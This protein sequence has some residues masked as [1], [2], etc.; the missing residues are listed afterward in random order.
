MAGL[1]QQ[2]NEGEARKK[3]GREKQKRRD[4]GRRVRENLKCFTYVHRVGHI[5][6]GRVKVHDVGRGFAGVQ[7]S[8]ES[9][10]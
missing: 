3:E 7:M 1:Y 6:D 4:G 5:S 8:R 9:L 2:K 10:Q